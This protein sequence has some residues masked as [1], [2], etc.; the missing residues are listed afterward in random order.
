M[1]DRD[2]IGQILLHVD[3]MDIDDNRRVLQKLIL[4]ELRDILGR[5]ESKARW[6]REEM[7]KKVRNMLD[8]ARLAPP[9]APKKRPPV[10]PPVLRLSELVR[11][12]RSQSS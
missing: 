3:R 2:P 8:T 12:N 1:R 6:V 9:P 11:G 7:R 10:T 4:E 5:L